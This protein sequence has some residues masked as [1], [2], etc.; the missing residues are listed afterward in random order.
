[1]AGR[2]Q[3]GSESPF[4]GNGFMGKSLRDLQLLIRGLRRVNQSVSFRCHFSIVQ[5][6]LIKFRDIGP[7]SIWTDL[8][9][10]II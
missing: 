8:R 10:T 5:D 3:A 2:G 4:P 7:Y 1:M 6:K 9:R